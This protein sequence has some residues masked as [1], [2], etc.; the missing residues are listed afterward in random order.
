MSMDVDNNRLWEKVRNMEAANKK[1]L[2]DAVEEMF[3]CI[4]CQVRNYHY[5]N[6]F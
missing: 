3:C 6:W 5:R 2:L 1:E 4:I